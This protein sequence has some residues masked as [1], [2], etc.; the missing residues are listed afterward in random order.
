MNYVRILLIT[1][2]LL[3]MHSIHT[4][5]IISLTPTEATATK[6]T[7]NDVSAVVLAKE[8]EKTDLEK[9]ND[10]LDLLTIKNEYWDSSDSTP[11]TSWQNTAFELATNAIKKDKDLASTL[12]TSFF[13]AIKT[14]IALEKGEFTKET[15]NLIAEFDAMIE[16]Q[17]T[18][19]VIGTKEVTSTPVA[20]EATPAPEP[21]SEPSLIIDT[22]PEIQA[23]TQDTTNT[24]STN[25]VGQASQNTIDEWN[26][27]LESIKS[28]DNIGNSI[29][30]AYELSR[31]LLLSGYNPIDLEKD[32][33]ASLETRMIQKKIHPNVIKNELNYFKMNI[34]QQAQPLQS[35]PAYS[36]FPQQLFPQQSMAPD[37]V[38]RTAQE[39]E[40]AAKEKMELEKLQKAYAEKDKQLEE[41]RKKEAQERMI[42]LA[43]A[44]KAQEEGALAKEQVY[45]LALTQK[46]LKEEYDKKREEDLAKIKKAQDDLAEH[47]KQTMLA[48]KEESE[49]GVFSTLSDWWYGASAQKPT[50]LSAEQQETLLNQMVETVELHLQSAAKETYKKLQATLLAVNS[51]EYWNENKA[52]PNQKWIDQMNQL[53]HEVVITYEIMSLKKITTD[54]AYALLAS[55]KMSKEKINK[56]I[57]AISL[58]TKD[59]QAKRKQQEAAQQALTQRRKDKK[60]QLVLAQQRIKAEEDRIIEEKKRKKQAAVTYRDEK[61]QWYDLLGKVAQNKQATPQENHAHVQEAVKKSQT[62]LQL[63]HDIPDKNKAS[64]GQKLK[65]KFSVALLE[66]QKNGNGP[67]NIYQTMDLFN[68]EVNKMMD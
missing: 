44:K 56:A 9:W 5:E 14:K 48:Q 54:I 40:Q 59:A 53:I 61:K 50:K 2:A 31:D 17:L 36:A 65:Q 25:E 41:Q 20:L 66:Q 10:H 27:I 51:A 12:K 18:P 45:E 62:L 22:Q 52:M 24:S 37:L 15:T 3:N 57:E 8:E 26:T 32:F 39:K 67:V 7:K 23:T 16:A 4:A 47:M 34:A 49:R 30:R 38:A 55:G 68:N 46:K 21:V 29:N 60:E 19:A 11:L 1:I 6:P 33:K 42:E 58:L 13:D 63:A 35:Q 64:V 28:D 43:A